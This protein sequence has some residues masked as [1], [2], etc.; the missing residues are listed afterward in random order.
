MGRTPDRQTIAL[1]L[2]NTQRA[3]VDL[4]LCDPWNFKL[5][6]EPIKERALR[7]ADAVLA[8]LKAGE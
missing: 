7:E 4:E 1:A 5:M 2:I 8:T 6:H 3:F